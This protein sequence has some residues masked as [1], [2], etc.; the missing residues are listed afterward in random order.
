MSGVRSWLARIGDHTLQQALRALADYTEALD[1]RLQTLDQNV[2]KRGSPV[3]A[4]SQRIR[5]VEDPKYDQDVVN[6]RTL[7]Q[8]VEGALTVQEGLPD[9]PTTDAGAPPVIPPPTGT[10]TATPDTLG[11]GG[12]NVTF[13]WTSQHATSVESSLHGPIALSGN[14]VSFVAASFT[15]TLTLRGPGGR[16]TYQ[17]TVTVA[18]TPPP[19][20]PPTGT[21]QAIPST[22][23]AG[24]SVTLT[25][26]STN[27]TTASIT[28]GVGNVTPVAVGNVAV[29]PTQT[30]TYELR[31]VGAGGIAILSATVTVS[32]PPP[33]PGSP[34]A[35]VSGWGFTR[36]GVRF[37]WRGF[38]AFTALHDFLSPDN[39]KVVGAR[40]VL[41]EFAAAG[42]TVPRILLTINDANPATGFWGT[43]GYNLYP[44][45][46]PAYDQ[47]L[48]NLVQF[49]NGLG[50]MPEL[51][52]FGDAHAGTGGGGPVSGYGDQNSRKAFVERIARVLLPY[53]G[54]FVQIANESRNIGFTSH[55]QVIDLGNAYRVIDTGRILTLTGPDSGADTET[56]YLTAPASYAT[57]HIDRQTSP[58]P[59]E[60]VLRH[61]GNP[62][63]MN[64]VYPAVSD[65]PINAGDALYGGSDPNY[66]HW[67]LFG[68]MAQLMGFSPTFH[69]EGGLFTALS[70]GND[71]I[72]R[73][74]L[75]TAMGVPNA[76]FGYPTPD[77]GGA[78]F[79]ALPTGIVFGPS[80]WP[81]SGTNLG[82]IGRTT[83]SGAAYGV[84]FGTAALPAVSAG[85]G[86]VQADPITSGLFNF[87]GQAG[88]FTRI[89]GYKVLP[90]GF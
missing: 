73:N 74:A 70:G 81:N 67:W 60:W 63:I 78:L 6:L 8:Y 41:Q 83:S 29:M 40:T 89:R 22:I 90:A 10:F 56:Y 52:I 49:C 26:T 54:V 21:F 16:T 59:Y 64:G 45:N 62:T 47:M 50:M 82:L 53:R 58:R 75:F 68:A 32:A 87:P 23:A 38:T 84:T 36:D 77:Q 20:P 33:P 65:E 14:I 88:P 72:C 13:A 85:W 42:G 27:A 28:P 66:E 71:L 12:G 25:W 46:F 37:P 44:P 2:L 30:T 17:L 31:L 19:T 3:D 34:T 76:G 51:V 15:V 7:R 86:T 18:T 9:R 61:Y 80:P 4:H 79:G 43:K 11:A 57:V 55:T 48:I 35:G 1:A 24:Q 69:Y 39:A 5:N